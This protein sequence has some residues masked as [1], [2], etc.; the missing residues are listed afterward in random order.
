MFPA[1]LCLSTLRPTDGQPYCTE[2]I[3]A[4][5]GGALVS[6]VLPFEQKS[7]AHL[8]RK[9]AAHISISGVQEKI[10]LRLVDGRLTPAEAD[11]E[12]ILKPV[13]QALAGSLDLVRDVPANEHFTMQFAAQVCGLRAA[14]CGLVF[15][16]DGEPAY[17][18]RRFDRDAKTG[19]KLA[20]EDFCQLAGRS[21][22]SHGENY[23]YDGTHEELGRLLRQHCAASE[24][25][26]ERLFALVVF[27]YLCGN[28]DAHMKNFSVIETPE[29]GCTLSPAYDLLC[30]TLHLPGESRT[31][32]EF[33]D[34]FMTLSFEANGF[35]KRPDFLALAI[36]FGIPSARAESHL[37]KHAAAFRDIEPMAARSLLSDEARARYLALV[38]DRLIAVAD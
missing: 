15:F 36:R 20:Q 35:F 10:S 37:D 12:F 38:K 31:A 8:R 1:N 13:P 27:N 5:W 22:A 6:P 19:R 17:V 21:R 18:T 16:P 4:L 9:S 14:A 24:Q 29:G 30:T 28:G 25:D 2:A 32:L 11:G 34:D 3:D 26:I 33:F 7:F 23:K